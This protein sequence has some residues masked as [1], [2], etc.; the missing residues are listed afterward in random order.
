MEKRVNQRFPRFTHTMF[1]RKRGIVIFVLVIFMISFVSAEVFFSQQPKE[2]YALG[3]QISLVI[4][5]DGTPGWVNVN[6]KCGENSSSGNKVFF[7]YLTENE[8]SLPVSV[9]LTRDF[10]REMQGDCYF[11]MV[12][13]S[14]TKSSLHFQ[15]SSELQIQ[16]SLDKEAYEPKEVVYFTGTASKNSGGN[17]D[18]GFAEIKFSYN[19]IEAIV[20]VKEGKFAGNISLQENIPSGDYNLDIFVYEKDNKDTI[21]NFHLLN[22]SISVLSKA[23]NLEIALTGDYSPNSDLG[24]TANLYDQAD[25]TMDA[26]PVAFTLINPSGEQVINVLS[27]TGTTEYYKIK[28][29]ALVGYWNL[30]AEAADLSSEFNEIYVRENVEA[31]FLLINDTLVVRNVGNVPYDKFVEIKIGE[32]Y[33]KVLALNLSLGG[34]VE[35]ELEA[36]DGEYDVSVNDGKANINGVALLT[37]EV[38]GIKDENRGSLGF[39]NKYIFSWIIIIGILGLFVFVSARK[40]LNRKSV[41]FAKD[42]KHNKDKGGVIK[43]SE[44]NKETSVN[45]KDN[46]KQVQK[47]HTADSSSVV[48]GEKQKATFLSLNIKEDGFIN[49]KGSSS[50]EAINDAVDLISKARGKVYRSSGHVIG[51]FAPSITKTFDNSMEVIRVAD[52]IANKFKE[53]NKKYAQKINFGVGIGEG[54]IIVDNTGGKF[55]FTPLGHSLQIVKKISDLAQND[56]LLSEGTNVSLGGKLKTIANTS[57]GVKTY[58]IN[59]VID[60]GH[61]SQFLNKFLDRNYRKL[62]DFRP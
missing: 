10:L 51:I 16:I 53:H 22:S 19:G 21:T 23:K 32:N 15:I 27:E 58:S 42:F 2:T 43:V 50:Y 55:L 41:L 47:G 29:N 48:Q 36:P 7:H 12:F 38:V 54:D 60:K 28:K 20:P 34:S 18:K 37:G 30:S 56:L 6:L 44:D 1:V 8:L 13:D 11:S 45:I 25:E 39:F 31:E 26:V 49:R 35:F 14:V 62:S 61:H 9:P 52:L 57:H 4:G 5:S 17:V 33:T 24:F 40:I 46:S 3:E 59:D